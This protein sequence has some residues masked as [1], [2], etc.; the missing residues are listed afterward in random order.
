[1][2]ASFM[3][4]IRAFRDTGARKKG[5]M[6]MA[7]TTWFDGPA[8]FKGLAM[9]ADMIGMSEG[10]LHLIGCTGCDRCPVGVPEGMSTLGGGR[11]ELQTR[12][13]G[14]FTA[15]LD[16]VSALCALSGHKDITGLS[17]MDLFAVDD[18]WASMTGLPLLGFE[19]R[20]P[21]WEH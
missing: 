13:K 7:A 1:M 18:R 20:L 12:L 2:E 11:D 8:A 15:V 9:G 21:M 4:A 3:S 14:F 19:R 10:I 16:R 5:V 6:L 17:P